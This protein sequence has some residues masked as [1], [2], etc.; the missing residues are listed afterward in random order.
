MENAKKV[1]ENPGMLKSEKGTNPV[2]VDKWT[3]G[4]VLVNVIHNLY[5]H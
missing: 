1:V 3:F 5:Q 2:N 4:E